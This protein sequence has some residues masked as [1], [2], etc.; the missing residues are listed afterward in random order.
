MF[1]KLNGNALA[2]ILG[3]FTSL[4]TAYAVLDIDTLDFHVFKTYFKLFVIGMPAVGGYM[5]TL[6]KPKQ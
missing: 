2:T 4:C 6:I 5:S 3:L 1:N